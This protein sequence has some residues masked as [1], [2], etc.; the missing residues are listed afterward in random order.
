MK[1]DRNILWNPSP[2]AIQHSQMA[3]FL[4]FLNERKKCH[5]RNYDELYQ[6]SVDHIEDFWNQW[7]EKSRI[8]FEGETSPVLESWMMPGCQF[9][10]N[11]TLNFA[12]NLL[13][14]NDDQPALISISES[15]PRE[16]FTYSELNTKVAKV[17]QWFRS[18]GVQPGDRVAGYVPNSSE[19][20]IAMLAASS[21]GAM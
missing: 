4:A 15:R 14:F 18:M 2:E 11:V 17:Q 19:A 6:W 3:E 13:R 7:L 8:L 9:F 5:L 12:Q 10:P 16:V 1:Q 21:L 20:V